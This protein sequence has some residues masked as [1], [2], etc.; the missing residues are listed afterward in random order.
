MPRKLTLGEDE[1]VHYHVRRWES[2]RHV[3]IPDGVA[4]VL[5]AR[6]APVGDAALDALAR[7]GAIDATAAGAVLQRLWLALTDT[8]DT[9]GVRLQALMAYVRHH[10]DRPAVQDW[11]SLRPEDTP[12]TFKWGS[13][14]ALAALVAVMIHGRLVCPHVVRGLACHHAAA[15]EP[16]LFPLNLGVRQ[17][18]VVVRALRDAALSDRAGLLLAGHAEAAR[19]LLAEVANRAGLTWT[20]IDSA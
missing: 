16:Y 7:T 5:A 3:V 2:A 1:A 11:R 14:E 13:E 19:E 15:V 9:E 8:L 4:R 10:G 18:E 17:F 6:L 20:E 12:I